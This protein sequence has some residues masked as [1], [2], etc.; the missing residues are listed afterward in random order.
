MLVR[1][2]AFDVGSGATKMQVSDVNRSLRRIVGPVLFGQE[3]PVPFGA[4][5]LASADGKIPPEMITKGLE[6][7]RDLKAIAVEL[8]VSSFSAVAT[9]VF[10]KA[11]NGEEFL[12][13]VRADLDIPIEIVTQQLEAELGFATA[14]AFDESATDNLVSWDSGGA[15]F[16][17]TIAKGG[18]MQMYLGALGTSRT[19]KTLVGGV[20]GLPLDDATMQAVNPVSMAEC[21]RLVEALCAELAD[22][23]DWLGNIET[24]TSIGGPNSMFSVASSVLGGASTMSSETIRDALVQCV[25]KSDAELQHLVDFE[26]ADPVCLVVP[27]LCLFHSVAA[28]LARKRLKSV[29]FQPCIGSCA[30][31]LVTE[32]L[33]RR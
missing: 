20:R 22:V 28:H 17:I 4:A 25:G 6:T 1:R 9:E 29:R 12:A 30:G 16:Q 32:G 13:R 24:I 15:S 7:L 10:R 14:L 5:W 31:L 21:D 23:P 11:V 26:F 8:G 33:W 18:A 3:R 2:A 19:L 27:K